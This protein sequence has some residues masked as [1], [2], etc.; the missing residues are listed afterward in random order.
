MITLAVVSGDLAHDT[1]AAE[2]NLV[3]WRAGIT[4]AQQID[5]DARPFVTFIP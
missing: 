2:R 1:S 3:S 5:G 4:F